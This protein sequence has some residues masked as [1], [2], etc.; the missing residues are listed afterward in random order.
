MTIWA[1][2]ESLP[3]SSNGFDTQER[4]HRDKKTPRIL[5]LSSPT[6]RERTAEEDWKTDQLCQ[7]GGIQG[8]HV[9]Q[10]RAVRQRER[11][12]TWKYPNGKYERHRLEAGH[13]T[14]EPEAAGVGFW[15]GRGPDCSRSRRVT[16]VRNDA[17]DAQNR[18]TVLI[19]PED[20]TGLRFDPAVMRIPADIGPSATMSK[21]SEKNRAKGLRG[22][23]AKATKL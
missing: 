23:G 6:K 3:R 4:F 22:D 12:R 11:L 19:A 18:R 5:I 13:E 14:V 2:R 17:A 21:S 20:Y 1:K 16:D 9:G 7:P 15:G 10:C 8:V